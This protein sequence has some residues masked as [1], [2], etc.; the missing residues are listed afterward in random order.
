[1]NGIVETFRRGS[2]NELRAWRELEVVVGLLPVCAPMTLVFAGV[3]IKYDDAVIK[4]SIS[5]EQ[6]VCLRVYKQT[7][8]ASQV[9]RIIAAAILS[10]M[11]DLHEEL[12]LIRKLQDLVVLFRVPA[13]PHVIFR[14]DE[15][16][17]LGG[18][19]LVALPWTA[20]RL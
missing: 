4:V 10:C 1:M 6:L 15:D 11:P 17:M 9:L 7:G 2:L 12:S 8:R 19:P 18:K 13:E 14:V 3:R 16:P 5:H 20:P